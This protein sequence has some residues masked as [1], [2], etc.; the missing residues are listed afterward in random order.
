MLLL[1]AVWT[2]QVGRAGLAQRARPWC[3]LDEA[4]LSVIVIDK[5]E[6]YQLLLGLSYFGTRRWRDVDAEVK[7]RARRRDWTAM[8]SRSEPKWGSLEFWLH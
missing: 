6:Y 2:S 5:L 1:F 4:L 3:V 7:S 8:F